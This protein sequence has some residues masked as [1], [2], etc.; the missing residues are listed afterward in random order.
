[1]TPKRDQIAAAINELLA[2]ARS[3][4]QRGYSFGTAGNITV[5]VGDTVLIER[6]SK[7]AGPD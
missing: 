2:A 3:L 1:M 4:Y 5:R 7:T 6:R